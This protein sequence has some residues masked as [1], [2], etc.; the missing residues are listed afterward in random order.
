MATKLLFEL[1]DAKNYDLELT[2]K[3]SF[4]SSLYSQEGKFWVKHAGLYA[5]LLSL[6]QE[7]NVLEAYIEQDINDEV[8][9]AIICESGLWDEKPSSR[10]SKLRNVFKEHIRALSELFPGVRLS[11]APHDF[12]CILIA[13]VLSKRTNYEV[14]VRKW[15]KRFWEKWRCDLEVIANLQPDEVRS[16]GTS[17]QLIDLVKVLRDYVK[18][19]PRKGGVEDLRRALMLCWGVGPKIADAILLF[20]TKSPWIVPCD[21]HLQ[22]V[23]KRLGWVEYNV[24]L[25][26]KTLCLNYHCDECNDRYGPCLREVIR[27]LFHGFGGWVQTLTYL[28][29]SSLCTSRKPKCHLCH[30]VLREYC[31]EKY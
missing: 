28:F 27:N 15:V 8:R 14:F 31:I 26:A 23:S 24:R 9:E 21:A 7:G 18:V 4:V 6:K 22:R 25:P 11:I 2:L 17:Y 16:I 3:P 19:C 5:E 13:V 29:G 12:N 30:P 1:D 10:V 20:T